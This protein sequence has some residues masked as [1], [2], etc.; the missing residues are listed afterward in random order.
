M[1]FDSSNLRFFGV[2][3]QPVQRDPPAF[4]IIVAFVPFEP[5]PSGPCS[6]TANSVVLA[7]DG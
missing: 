6:S 1:T 5:Y 2:R 3:R 4:V 7:Q